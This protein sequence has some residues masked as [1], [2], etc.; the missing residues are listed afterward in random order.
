MLKA[1][2]MFDRFQGF[3]WAA[4]EQTVQTTGNARYAVK[5]CATLFAARKFFFGKRH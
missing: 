4:E 2:I 1:T 3:I 5:R